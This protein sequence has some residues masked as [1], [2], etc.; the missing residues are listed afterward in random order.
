MK[1]PQRSGDKLIE[2]VADSTNLLAMNAAIE[3]AHAGDAGRGFAVVADEIRKLSD[4]TGE[5]ART[6]GSVLGSMASRVTA[7]LDASEESFASFR[8]IE[9]DSAE[10]AS[11]LDGIARAMDELASLSV[12]SLSESKTMAESAIITMASFLARRLTA[13][14]ACQSRIIG[15]NW[16][17]ASSQACR[18]VEPR[19]AAKAESSTNGTVG[20]PGTNRPM[21]PRPRLA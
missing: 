17:C 5:N 7:A 1:M 2:S 20:R 16:R 14:F 9:E 18:R 6:I 15:P 21:K 10:L 11:A 13:P 3:A 19:A 4:S 12:A 8:T